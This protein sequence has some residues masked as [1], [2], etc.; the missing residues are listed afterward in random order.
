M[1]VQGHS[2]GFVLGPQ[3]PLHTSQTRCCLVCTLGFH[4]ELFCRRVSTF[5]GTHCLATETDYRH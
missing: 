1:R 2:R 5:S 4:L 3:G